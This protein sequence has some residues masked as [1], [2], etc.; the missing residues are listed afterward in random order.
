MEAYDA[1]IVNIIQ[2]VGK[3]GILRKNI[4]IRLTQNQ[5]KGNSEFIERQKLL[6]SLI[7]YTTDKEFNFAQTNAIIDPVLFQY[8]VRFT[9]W[10]TMFEAQY[11]DV[12][13][14]FNGMEGTTAQKLVLINNLIILLIPKPEPD[15]RPDEE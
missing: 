4:L 7:P 14:F 10:I 5:Y 2:N 13:E 6:Y 3:M 8:Q 9:H 15:E 1:L 11:G 12:V